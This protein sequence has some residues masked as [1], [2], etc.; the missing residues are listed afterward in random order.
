MDNQLLTSRIADRTVTVN[1]RK[2]A[3]WFFRDYP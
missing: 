1:E 3:R 2:G